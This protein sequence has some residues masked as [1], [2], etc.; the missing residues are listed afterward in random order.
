MVTAGFMMLFQ[1]GYFIFEYGAVRRKNADTVL[2][3]ALVIFV[4]S[5]LSVYSLGYGFANGSTY[6][7]GFKDYFT[8][9]VEGPDHEGLETQWVLLFAATSMTAQMSVAGIHERAKMIVAFVY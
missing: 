2:I 7:I 8:P 5:V 9:F 1:L 3:K 4:I 6:V